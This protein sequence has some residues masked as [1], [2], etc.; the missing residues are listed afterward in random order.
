MLKMNEAISI[1]L[2]GYL[3][4]KSLMDDKKIQPLRWW[5]R[6][7]VLSLVQMMLP[8]GLLILLFNDLL[9]TRFILIGKILLAVF[10]TG[11]IFLV[12][13]TL[14]LVHKTWPPASEIKGRH[15]NDQGFHR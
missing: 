5:L 7:V 6:R 3:L 13:W 2:E 11:C 1:W 10:Y 8:S 4:P 15:N 12:M 14:Q 9:S